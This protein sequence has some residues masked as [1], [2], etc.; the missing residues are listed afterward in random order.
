MF[1][2]NDKGSSWAYASP[3]FARTLGSPHLALMREFAGLSTT[4]RTATEV[5]WA[6]GMRGGHSCRA[7]ERSAAHAC[8]L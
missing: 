6:A 8:P 3:G 4:H 1:I 5:S 2:V 7:C